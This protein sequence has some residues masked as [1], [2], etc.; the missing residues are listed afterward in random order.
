MNFVEQ[1]QGIEFCSQEEAFKNKESTFQF[2]Y[3]HLLQRK[4]RVDINS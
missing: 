3:V 1:M 2:V 4:N